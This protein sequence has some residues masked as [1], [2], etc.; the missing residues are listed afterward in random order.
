[1]GTVSG[2]GPTL[3]RNP[4]GGR[5]D[6]AAV[7]TAA[8]VVTVTVAL[9]EVTTEVGFT[10]QFV[11]VAAAGSEQVK[12]TTPVKP[13]RAR[14]ATGYVASGGPELTVRLVCPGVVASSKFGGSVTL[15]DSAA[16]VLGAKL[17]S[18]PYAAMIECDPTAS[19]V[20]ANVATPRAFSVS[21][22]SAVDPSLKVTIPVGV[23]MLPAS[24]DTVATKMTACPVVA[25]LGSA[26]TAVVVDAPKIKLVALVAVPSG[27]VTVMGPVVAPVGTVAVIEVSETTVKLVAATPLNSMPVAPAKVVPVIVT[28]F[29]ARPLA[30]VKEVMAGVT[31]K[32]VVLVK[33]LPPGVVTAMGPVVA[34][35]GTVAVIEVSETT[36]KLVAATPLNSTAVAP[37]KL[38]PVI[39]TTVPTGPKV[40]VNGLKLSPS[41]KAVMSSTAVGPIAVMLI[42]PIATPGGEVLK[43]DES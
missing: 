41:R 7:I 35:V 21:V 1:M 28:T 26:V 37:V 15:N 8:L 18:P 30:G 38:V 27:V 23:P 33:G 42:P 6:R 25:R 22:P 31:V 43:K 39:V 19:E 5:S 4:P 11:A 20:V 12:F 17:A 40:G 13:L 9:P 2:H 36:V 10:V 3:Q 34:P 29:P 24:F 32:R 16:D 14:T